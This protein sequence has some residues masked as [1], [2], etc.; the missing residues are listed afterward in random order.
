ME[1]LGLSGGKLSALEMID[2]AGN[3]SSSGW[4]F[5]S[6]LLALSRPQGVLVVVCANTQLAEQVTSDLV[7]LLGSEMVGLFPH[8]ETLPF[9]R[10]SPP[11]D[12]VGARVRILHGLREETLPP[13]Y[14]IV[15][16][17]RSLVQRMG[18]GPTSYGPPLRVGIERNPEE[19]VQELVELGYRR[20]YQTE[21]RGDFSVRGSIIDLF[22]PAEERPVRIDFFGSEIDGIALF[23]PETQLSFGSVESVVLR[24]AREVVLNE[25]IRRA[26]R[27]VKTSFTLEREA[28]ERAAQGEY[29]DGLESWLPWLEDEETV[30][31]DLLGEMDTVVLLEP[32][33]LS[34]RALDIVDEERSLAESLAKTWGIEETRELPRLHVNYDRALSSCRAQI[35]VVGGTEVDGNGFGR[36]G[37]SGRETQQ[38]LE[39]V[40]TC[41]AQGY[42]VVV[43][44]ESALSASTMGRSFEAEGFRVE[45]DPE[46]GTGPDS[47]KGALRIVSGIHLSEGVILHPLRTAVLAE[48]DLTGRRRSHRRQRPRTQRTRVEF[49]ALSVG[50]YVVHDVHGVARYLGMTTRTM[51]GVERDYLLLEYRGS[52]RIY[53]PSD[54]VGLITPYN[55]GE[56]PQLS[57]LGGSDWQATKTKARRAAREIAQELVVL[58]Q[59]RVVAPGHRFAPD[60]P[61]QEEIEATF[62]FELTRDQ[63]RAIAE[64]KADMEDSKPM[65]RLVCGD[66]GFGKTEIALRAAFKAV[67]DGKQVAVLVPTTLLASQHFQTF[68]ERF[69]GYPLRVEMLSRFLTPAQ[70]RSVLRGLS[71]KRVDIVVGTHRL[72]G[73]EVEFSDLGLLVVDEEQRFGVSHKEA[74][75]GLRA[76]VDVLTLSATP[77]PRTLEMSLTGIRD[78][79]LLH[80]PPLERR[81]ILTHVGPFDQRAISEAIRRELLRDGQVFY[82]HNRVQDIEA[83]RRQLEELVPEARIAVAHG[84]MDEGSLEQIVLDFWEQRFD[85]L[86]CTTIIESGIDM[87]TVNTLIVDRSD[88]LGLGQLHQLRGRVGRSG[89]RAYAY[90]FFPPE[91]ALSEEAF[92]RLRTIGENTEL[93]SGFRIAMRD[94]EIRGAGNLLGADQSGHM[95]AVGYDLYVKMVQEAVAELKGEIPE[96]PAEEIMIDLPVSASIPT[97]YIGREDLRL[98][99]YRRCTAISTAAELEALR[100]ELEDRFGTIPESV[101]RLLAIVALRIRCRELSVSELSLKR[102]AHG[103]GL[104]FRAKPVTLRTSQQLRLRRLYPQAQL[105][106]GPAELVIP[107]RSVADPIVASLEILDQIV[108]S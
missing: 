101:D 98:E 80:T 5:Y 33:R 20:E 81:P 84:Q 53:V 56:T 104:M 19:L 85:V 23:D 60:T 106:E 75:K 63:A 92:E 15:T 27:E 17:V 76:G 4:P 86:V 10:V 74:I 26:A 31:A 71:E 38:L 50:G 61:W 59:K 34:A 36:W 25:R 32:A 99:A 87:P 69:Q 35:I 42:R 21:N 83:V 95:A 68:S 11:S 100:V 57:R 45:I 24:E 73:S 30:I 41:L 62:P 78:L 82:V 103:V 97:S 94:L 89:L 102:S 52:D 90:L 70:S 7:Q 58:Y 54:Q 88:L 79:S 3:V 64:V 18:S 107:L 67:Q 108:A 9:E 6:A 65:D 96:Q 8:W 12:T 49:E 77:I 13:G 105:K 16:T 93:G 91:V 47:S 46:E 28:L 37:F 55:G 72:L 48:G 29:F 66:V 22:D 43:A 14:V 51:A 44:A 2:L 40:R 1:R 39:R